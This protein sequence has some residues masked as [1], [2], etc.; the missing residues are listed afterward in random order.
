[1]KILY[2]LLFLVSLCFGQVDGKV[3]FEKYC[4]G[5]HH[6]TSEAFGPSFEQI[7]NTRNEAQIMAQIYDPASSYKALG[8]KRTAMPAFDLKS[9]ELKA[10]TSYILSFKK[11]K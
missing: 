2:F 10:I 4:W 9:D 6:Q 5:C 11:G 1:M 3:V 8:Y 7:A